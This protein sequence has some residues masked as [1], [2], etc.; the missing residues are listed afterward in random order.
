MLLLC[1][2]K[3]PLGHPRKLASDECNNVLRSSAAAKIYQDNKSVKKCL[4]QFWQLYF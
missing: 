4:V 3:S 1:L 2:R